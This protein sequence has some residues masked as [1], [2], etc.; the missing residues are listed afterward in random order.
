MTK[1]D[2]KKEQFRRRIIGAPPCADFRAGGHCDCLHRY[3]VRHPFGGAS[4]KEGT[5]LACGQ[6]FSMIIQRG[7]LYTCGMNKSGQLG[8]GQADDCYNIPVK[9]MEDV[10]TAAAGLRHRVCHH[11]GRHAV[12]LGRNKYGQ[13]ADGTFDNADTP[14]EIMSDVTAVAAGNGHVLA[15]TADGSVYSWGDN[16]YNLIGQSDC[17][18]ADGVPCQSKPVKIMDRNFWRRRI[19]R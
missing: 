15:I 11:E 17:E 6:Q 10:K 19:R 7:T 14:V 3:P 2:K 1:G 13:L 9:T 16:S 8:T 18:N 5:S 4:A 12:R